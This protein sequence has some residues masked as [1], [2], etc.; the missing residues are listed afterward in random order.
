MLDFF[1]FS[2]PTCPGLFSPHLFICIFLF[3]DILD[4]KDKC[5]SSDW[6]PCKNIV[7]HNLLNFLTLFFLWRIPVSGKRHNLSFLIFC[8]LGYWA[9]MG[10]EFHHT[11]QFSV[12]VEAKGAF[13]NML[14]ERNLSTKTPISE[15]EQGS[16]TCQ[17]YE[18]W[19]K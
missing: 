2:L 14:A 7:F 10:T 19:S 6:I 3:E 16:R 13:V 11:N 17:G 12:I 5:K 8:E 9:K 4:N 18:L 15:I 1:P